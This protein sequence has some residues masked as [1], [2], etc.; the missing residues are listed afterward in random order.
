MSEVLI[1]EDDSVEIYKL[2]KSN[3][4]STLVLVHFKSGYSTV[5]SH[6]QW[7]VLNKALRFELREPL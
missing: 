4:K 5:Y 7:K 2:F 3:L 6:S 1:Y